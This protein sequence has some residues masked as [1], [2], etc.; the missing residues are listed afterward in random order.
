LDHQFGLNRGFDVYGDQLPRQPNGQQA[1]ERPAS[2]VVS[3]AIAWIHQLAPA[4]KQSAPSPEPGAA[5]FLW[6]H[7]FDP[8]AP[9]GDPRSQRR[10]LDGDD[11]EIATADR[12]IGRLLEALGNVRRETLIVAAGDHGEAFGEHGEFAHSIFVY[13]TTLRVP[14]IVSGPSVA[15]GTRV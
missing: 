5:F 11:D 9:Y 10:V 2:E 7:L 6:V 8:H 4:S 13:D 1:N 14:L 15:A 3:D 12:E